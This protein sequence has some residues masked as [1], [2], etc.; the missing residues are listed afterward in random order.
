M[1]QVKD[2]LR[3]GGKVVLVEYRAEDPKVDIRPEHK[4]TLEQIKK[5][6]AAEGFSFVSSD[7]S[8]PKQRIV[9]F[10]PAP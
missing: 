3:N 10:V 4:M 9:T 5:E 6:L 2:S 1:G 7:E 8:L